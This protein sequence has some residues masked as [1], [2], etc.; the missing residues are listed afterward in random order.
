MN[1]TIDGW[2]RGPSSYRFGLPY[3]TQRAWHRIGVN[4]PEADEDGFV[5]LADLPNSENPFDL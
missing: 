2:E 4:E 3:G 1:N 5:K